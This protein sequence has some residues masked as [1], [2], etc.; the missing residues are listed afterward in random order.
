MTDDFRISPET[1]ALA[2][3]AGRLAN[4]VFDKA[5]EGDSEGFEAEADAALA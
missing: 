4:A 5:L 3:L 1:M 2:T